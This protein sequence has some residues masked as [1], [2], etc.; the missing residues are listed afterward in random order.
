MPDPLDTQAL[1][2]LLPTLL[3]HSTSSPLP[4]PTDVIAALVHTIHTSLDFRLTP[5][6]NE[7]LQTNTAAAAAPVE[8]E[9]D[10]GASDT[11]TAVDNDEGVSNVE[12]ALGEGWNERGEDTYKLEYRHAQSSMVFRVRVGR[13]GGRVQIDA[14]AEVSFH[15]SEP[16]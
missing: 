2:L 14:T 13:M 16:R 15:Q 11:D 1:L 6:S 7:T 8:T 9:V 4:R 5:S 12:N 3:P 10:D